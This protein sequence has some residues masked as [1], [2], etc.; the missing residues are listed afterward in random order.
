M[1]SVIIYGAC[2]EISY[3]YNVI[4]IVNNIM[5]YKKNHSFFCFKDLDDLHN[6]QA[7]NFIFNVY[8]HR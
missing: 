1:V 2:Y 3:E 8:Q 6:I 7:Y 4:K 5:L